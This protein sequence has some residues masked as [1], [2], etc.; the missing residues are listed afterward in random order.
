MLKK[1][2]FLLLIIT[3]SSHCG[4]TDPIDNTGSELV[5]ASGLARIDDGRVAIARDEAIKDAQRNAVKQKIGSFISGSTTSID[6]VFESQIIR[7]ESS[8]FIENYEII[9][10]QK[11][12]NGSYRVTIRAEVKERELE[13]AF[14]SEYKQK[15]AP[16]FAMLSIEN[17]FNHEVTGER[18]VVCSRVREYFINKRFTFLENSAVFDKNLSY[19]DIKYIIRG[20]KK[21]PPFSGKGPAPQIIMLCSG[22]AR[23]EGSIMQ[24]DL[25][26]VQAEA[27]IKVLYADTGRVITEKSAGS[28]AAHIS[29]K[30]G[31]RIAGRAIAAEIYESTQP[32]IMKAASETRIRKIDV[33]LDGL[34]YPSVLTLK[35]ILLQLRYV[36]ETELIRT[37]NRTAVLLLI[38]RTDATVVFRYLSG[39]RQFKQKFTVVE[40][41]LSN[42]RIELSLKKN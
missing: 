34:D 42:N 27:R 24:S 35:N 16:D 7:S 21:L 38:A 10:E 20:D 1:V 22:S 40:S 12:D 41:S 31:A 32:A 5:E 30:K 14:R 8:G 6:G 26:S 39:D 17:L 3:L 11:L 23:S 15:S 18:T 25:N 4:S 28:A 33:Y 13:Q 29:E 9:E 37:D 36:D 19:Y 2:V